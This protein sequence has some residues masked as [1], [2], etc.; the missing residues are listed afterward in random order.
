MQNDHHDKG[1]QKVIQRYRL[2]LRQ[3]VQLGFCQTALGFRLSGFSCLNESGE[4]GQCF[5]NI[6]QLS[7]GH[8]GAQLS[9]FVFPLSP[10]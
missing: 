5:L 9:V 3:P 8:E 7:V 2:A 1:L 10:Q 6:C 4:H